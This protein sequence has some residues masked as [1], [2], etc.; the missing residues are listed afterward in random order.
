MTV[1][2]ERLNTM[3]ISFIAL[4]SRPLAETSPD[5]KRYKRLLETLFPDSIFSIK[6]NTVVVHYD[7]SPEYSQEVAQNVAD[8]QPF[9][10]TV[11]L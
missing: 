9:R 6:D 3:C 5:P 2:P 7:D 1:Q 11:L 4:S 10:W 8:N